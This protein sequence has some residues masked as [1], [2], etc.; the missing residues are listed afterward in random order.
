MIDVQIV[1]RADVSGL[2]RRGEVVSVAPGYA[3]NY[4]IPRGLAFHATAAT[5]D[6]KS[7]RLNSSHRL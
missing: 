5:Q 1:L 7:T 3:R 2:G 4:L 6:R